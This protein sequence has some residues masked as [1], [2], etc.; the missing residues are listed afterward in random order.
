MSFS[1]VSAAFTK[2]PWNTNVNRILI[3]EYTSLLRMLT[4][5]LTFS[6]AH[7]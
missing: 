2:N 4:F 5:P 3:Y 6:M 1:S 7:T